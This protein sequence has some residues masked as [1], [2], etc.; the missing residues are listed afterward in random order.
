MNLSPVFNLP[1]IIG[2]E[3]PLVGAR[4]FT[5]EAGSS[6][7]LLGTTSDQAGL[8]PNANPV[9]LNSSGQSPV[10]FWLTPGEAYHFVLTLPDGT[11]VLS[12]FDDVTGIQGAGGPGGSAA[13]W[14]SA[15]SGTY[16]APT[17][18]IVTG[19]LTAEF[20]VGN[21]VRATLL[22]GF[23]YGTVTAVAFSTPN[24]QVTIIND[25]VALNASMSLAEHSVLTSVG[26]TVDAAGVAYFD[27]FS[28]APMNNTVGWKIETMEATLTASIATTEAQRARSE[29]VWPLVGTGTLTVT[30]TPPISSYS[31]SQIF[32]VYADNAQAGPCTVN[33]S[34]IGPVPLSQYDSAGNLVDLALAAGQMTDIAY[35]G[36]DFIALD[37]L[38]AAGAVVPRGRAVFTSNGTFE[39]PAGVSFLKITCLGGGGSGGAGDTVSIGGGDFVHYAGGNGGSGANSTIYISTTGGTT[40]SVGVGTGG[41]AGPATAG[42]TSSFGITIC[43]AG[44]GNHGANASG[45]AGSNGADASTGTGFILQGASGI[46]VLGGAYARGGQGGTLG[47]DNGT[48]GTAGYVT[49]EY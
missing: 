11:T 7:I 22:S 41:T 4:I 42:G 23:T 3:G 33:I 30:P 21:R 36:S 1:F 24:T 35:D 15:G 2:D 6:S 26:E 25:G 9:I 18:F 32:T 44:G 46:A 39:T 13:I 47:G 19:N 49:V 10:A 17:Q 37:A 16:V 29:L 28:Y 27:A 34:G 31:T 5:Y 8:V 48:N 20:A 45:A 40:Y 14:V 38:P 43:T 12:T